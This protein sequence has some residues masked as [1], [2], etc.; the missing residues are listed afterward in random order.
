MKKLIGGLESSLKCEICEEEIGTFE[1]KIC[2]RNVCKLDFN[3]E[4][5]ICKVCE[6]S[7]CEVCGE[8]LS[9]G[10]C[11]K[12]GKIIC[13]KCVGYNDGVRRYCKNCYIH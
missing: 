12:C 2:G 4:K 7:L 5:N 3:E 11:E 6:M 10:K 9:I 8:K 1:C 13:E